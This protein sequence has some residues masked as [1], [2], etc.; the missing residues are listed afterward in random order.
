VVE[1]ASYDGSVATLDTACGSSG[2]TMVLNE[3]VLRAS[4]PAANLSSVAEE[5]LEELRSALHNQTR[6]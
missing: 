1:K 5:L 3:P 2:I 4:N 6:V